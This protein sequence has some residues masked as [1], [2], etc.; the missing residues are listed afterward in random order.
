M[1]CQADQGNTRGEAGGYSRDGG[2]PMNF[3]ILV[4][5]SLI[6][7]QPKMSEGLWRCN[8][9]PARQPPPSQFISIAFIFLN[10]F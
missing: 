7:Q 9:A 2:G 5:A 1:P 8:A 3:P 4:Q 6:S 10:Y